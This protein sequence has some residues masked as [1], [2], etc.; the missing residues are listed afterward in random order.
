MVEE[1]KVIPLATIQA[2]QRKVLGHEGL[3]WTEIR[4]VKRGKSKYVQSDREFTES[5][6]GLKDIYVG[7]N[8]RSTQDGK[9]ESVGY[10]SCLVL[11]IDPN[12]AKGMASSDAQHKEATEIGLRIASDY[13]GTI[14][15]SSG[16]GCHVYFPIEPVKVVDAKALTESLKVWTNFFQKK[17]E[18]ATQK[19]DNIYDLP[20][21][22]RVWGTHNTKS[23]RPCE[24][25]TPI[26]EKRFKVPL[27]Q[28]PKEISTN[29]S[30]VEGSETETRF[31]RLL[32][33]STVLRGMVDGT[34]KFES[35]SEADYAFV[36]QLARAHFNKAEI[37]ALLPKNPLG[38]SHERSQDQ[39]AKDIERILSKVEGDQESYSLVNQSERYSK[40]L[41]NRKMGLKTGFAMFDEMVSGLKAQKVYLTAARPT[42]GKTTLMAQWLDHLASVEKQVCLCF[43]TEV[44]AEPIIDKIVSRRSKVSLKKFQN[45]D[46]KPEETEAV[47]KTIKT[48]NGLPL[49]IVEDFGLTVEKIETK[50]K[51]V[52]PTV[53]AIDYINAMKFPNGGEPNEMAATVRKIKEL[54]GDYNIPILL[55]AQLRRGDGKLELSALKGSGALEELCDVVS[56]LYNVGDKFDYP[57]KSVLDVMKSKYSATGPINLDFHRT[58]CEFKENN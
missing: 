44:G 37:R 22:I 55:F 36:C 45:G 2:L 15:V 24:P 41:R 17:Y 35:R 6:V 31:E 48:I 34:A 11:D 27:S 7:I 1:I 3:G 26:T 39:L 28:V 9:G 52:A 12:R 14:A 4:D 21:V 13:P 49:V 32:S 5:V 58:N 23:N 40:G 30:Q 29:T 46:F 8:P 38:K 47:E 33:T 16:S 56:F 51:E 19:I 43:P 42:S 53:V 10:V 50:M 25:I 57:T 20:R 18:T 54:A